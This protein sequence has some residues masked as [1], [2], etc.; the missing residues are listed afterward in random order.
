MKKKKELD[1]ARNNADIKSSNNSLNDWDDTSLDKSNNF[2]N[3]Q[4]YN[5]DYDYKLGNTLLDII[6]EILKKF[7]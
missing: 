4:D 7:F 6:L 2:L 5:N 3:K 1:Q